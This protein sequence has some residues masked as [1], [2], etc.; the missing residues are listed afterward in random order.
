MIVFVPL[1]IKIADMNKLKE[2]IV[3]WLKFKKQ[4]PDFNFVSCKNDLFCLRFFYY[5]S[6]SFTGRPFDYRNFSQNFKHSK[7]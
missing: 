1:L 4:I 5:V 7:L 6:N 3:R 2:I